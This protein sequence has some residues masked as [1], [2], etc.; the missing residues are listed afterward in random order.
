M[1]L[2]QKGEEG[3]DQYAEENALRDTIVGIK[4]SIK[5]LRDSVAIKNMS[6]VEKAMLKREI[7]EQLVVKKVEKSGDGGNGE[8][9]EKKQKKSST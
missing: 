9:D 1:L 8:E 7:E 5:E 3:T 4:G 6:N 2:L